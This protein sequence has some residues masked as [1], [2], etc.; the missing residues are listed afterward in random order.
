MVWGM[1][2]WAEVPDYMGSNPKPATYQLCDWGNYL[3]LGLSFLIS[4]ME[5]IIMPIL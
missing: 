2:V 3:T 1:N 5:I 4:K